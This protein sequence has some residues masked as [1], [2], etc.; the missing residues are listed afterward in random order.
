[1]EISALLHWLTMENLGRAVGAAFLTFV[2]LVA[3]AIARYV[4]RAAQQLWFF[5][6]SRQRA[7]HAVRR[8]K[9]KDGPREGQ[10][11]WLTT[12]I[13][14]PDS[15]SQS[16]AANP[17]L[18]IANLKGGVGKTTLAANIGAFLAKDW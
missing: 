7:L 10:G 17:V 9:V 14:Q 16:I 3:L 18:A 2:G 12:P 6:H 5:L 15:Y 1:M 13:Y 4:L 11:V 8:E